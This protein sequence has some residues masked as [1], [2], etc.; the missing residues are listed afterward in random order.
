MTKGST[1]STHRVR[2]CGVQGSFPARCRPLVVA[3]VALACYLFGYFHD[4]IMYVTHRY[5]LHR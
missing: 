1:R 5:V 3:R 4:A 2:V